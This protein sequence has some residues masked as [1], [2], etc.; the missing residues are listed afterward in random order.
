MENKQEFWGEVIFAYT[1]KQAIADGVLVDLM[2]GELG[3][4]VKEAGFRYPIAMTAE[5]FAE[6][7]DLTPAAKKAGCN[8][9]GRLWDVLTMLHWAI[10]RASDTNELIFKFYAVTDRPKP[11]L[12]R[13]K[14][15]VGPGDQGEPVIT[16]MLV[17]QD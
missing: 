2:Q 8:L 16:I 13:L 7:V 6:Y 11:R 15:V 1:R 12:C 14:S 9:K 3:E 4:L 10:K 5:A 17:N